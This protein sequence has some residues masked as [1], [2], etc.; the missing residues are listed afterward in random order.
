MP[1]TT[2]L[3]FP[4]MFNIAANQ[5]SVLE[6]TNSV[7]NRTRLLILTEPTE[8]YN[9]PDFGVGLKRHLWKYNNDNERGLVK[10]R[11]TQQLR[12]HEPCVYPDKTQYSDGLLFSGDSSQ[13]NP[14]TEH[15]TL[16][17][18]V[19]LQTVFKE[20]VKITLN[21]EDIGDTQ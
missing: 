15:N 4:N 9:N 5:V 11:I 8:L 7:A 17:L 20:D 10:D 14:L 13:N 18:T 6:D 21:P 3:A 16:A 2:S 1:E 12:L 19:A